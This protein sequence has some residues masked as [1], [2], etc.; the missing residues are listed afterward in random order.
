MKQAYDLKFDVNDAE[1]PETQMTS[2]GAINLSNFS[3][4]KNG[5]ELQLDILLSSQFQRAKNQNT[6]DQIFR[7]VQLF[8]VC[9]GCG[10]IYWEGSHLNR[11]KKNFS[12]FIDK[13]EMD[14]NFYGK[15]G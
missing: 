7:N 13:T 9:E 10:K 14:K 3:L 4:M 8:Y 1:M 5:V 12:D 15:P 2:L 6:L 11:V